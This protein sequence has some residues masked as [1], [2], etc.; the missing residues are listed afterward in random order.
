MKSTV[1]LPRK[2]RS[3]GSAWLCESCDKET[4]PSPRTPQGQ[5]RGASSGGRLAAPPGDAPQ[6]VH[7]PPSR[8]LIFQAVPAA[9]GLRSPRSLGTISSHVLTARSGKLSVVGTVCWGG[10]FPEPQDRCFLPAI[11][12]PPAKDRVPSL[13]SSMTMLIAS[14]TC[15]R[16]GK[17]SRSQPGDCW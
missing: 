16:W 11:W 15:R 9:A 8:R 13:T 7:S 5:A 3:T 14:R 6:P 1:F 10:F 17:G 4:A 12:I 2:A